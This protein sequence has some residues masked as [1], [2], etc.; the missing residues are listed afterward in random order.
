MSVT[1]RLILKT[2]T[3]TLRN[4]TSPILNRVKTP[5]DVNDRKPQFFSVIVFFANVA[6][7]Y[8]METIFLLCTC[9]RNDVDDRK[10][11]FFCNCFDH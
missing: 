7:Q 9:T 6:H 2:I 4:T 10:T 5:N 1:V 11:T 8:V 3:N